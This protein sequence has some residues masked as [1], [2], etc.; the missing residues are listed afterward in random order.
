MFRE[1]LVH[2]VL[3]E[4]PTKY[5]N[6]KKIFLFSALLLS[7]AVTQA[8]DEGWVIHADA[9]D[10]YNGVTMANGRIGLVS[11][12]RLFEVSD[13][14]LNGV[15]DKEE[16]GGV[17]R[18]VRA[19]LF[20]NMHLNVD[21]EEVNDNTITYWSQ[22]LNMKEAY[23]ET[24][25]R[26]SKAEI[27]SRCMALR[28]LPYMG[29]TLVEVTP[30]NNARV[31]VV[32]A[33]A[34]PG[35]TSERSSTFK[36][37]RDGHI[38]LPVFTSTAKTCTQMHDVATSSVFM[39]DG[40]RPRLE[41]DYGTG[42]N[43]YV[44]FSQDVEAGRTFR[45]ALVGAVCSTQDFSSPRDEAER[46]AIYALQS[47]I[48]TI[49]GGH[50]S[51]WAKLWQGD[52]VI[53][54]DEQS[55]KD[56]RLALY[57]LYSFVAPGTRQSIAPMGLSTSTGYNGHVFWD[58]ELWMFPPL[59]MLNHELARSMVDYRSD[60]LPKAMQRA[61]QFGFEG[62]MYPW[63]SDDTGEE[64]TPTWCL[65]GPFEHHI[66]A[67]VAISFWNYYCVTGDKEWLAVEGYPVLK[68]VADFWVSR[69]T[70]NGDGTFSIKN[71][72]GANEFAQNVDD[73]AFTNGSAKK[74]L[75]YAVMAAREL[76]RQPDGRWTTVADGMK[77]HYMESGV[78][79]ENARYN[80]EI[81]KQA[82]VNLLSYPLGIVTD[83]RRVADDLNY[84]AEKIFHNGPAMGNAILSILH[85]QLGDTE[86]AF[87]LFKKSY[88]P[89]R[90]PP[91]GVLSESANSNNPYF[92][93]GA[94]G[95]LQTVLCGFG[96]LR[97]TR[98]GIR[99]TKPLLP[100]QWK[101]LTLKG[102][103]PERKTYVIK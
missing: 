30:C 83:P 4:K 12:R 29:M 72:V 26:T 57:N 52:I 65:T 82:D 31:G 33:V 68:N 94:G 9:Q 10:N 43:Q 36:M 98:E 34:F 1:I 14:I 19:P 49:I 27:R 78:M 24:V 97:I 6:I 69:A 100:S 42:H 88:E 89:H 79:M 8:Q 63:E 17:S 21:G 13:I 73:N 46:M 23:L 87:R 32:N 59:L 103:G 99:Q 102:V 74:T 58:A 85:A 71:V 28:N 60:R 41:A 55:Q 70:D 96:G 48:D 16:A 40:E 22:S 25:V 81:I 66:T 56:V 101:S 91:F 45:F 3:N 5:M 64:A 51:E 18:V 93:T 2:F 54:G 61:D 53:E 75:E 95:M 77:F 80:G 35:E 38:E 20:T 37:L 84:Y 92:A 86:E 11:G 90:R 15:Y 44:T 47:D 7:T 62:C 67:D 50:V 39:F 76:G